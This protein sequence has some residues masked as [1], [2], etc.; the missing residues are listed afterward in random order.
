[1]IA[2]TVVCFVCVACVKMMKWKYDKNKRKKEERGA[3]AVTQEMT[4]IQIKNNENSESEEDGE[5]CVVFEQRPFGLVFTNKYDKKNLFIKEVVLNSA[6]EENNVIVGSKIV[7]FGKQ[8]V[9][10]L[11]G[12]NIQKMFVNKFGKQLPLKIT[13][14]KPSEYL[15]TDDGSGSSLSNVKLVGTKRGGGGDGGDDEM[16]KM[17]LITEAESRSHM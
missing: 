5:Y 13:F 11:G 3:V 9:E 6:A 8:N 17:S 15:V 14:R 4:L 7:R 16:Q 1:M 2:A 10:D 12:K